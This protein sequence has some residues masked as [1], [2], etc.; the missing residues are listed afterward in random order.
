[1]TY[2]FRIAIQSRIAA[3]HPDWIPA[4]VLFKEILDQGYEGKIRILS[5]YVAKLK[6]RVPVDQGHLI[7]TVAL[8]DH[9]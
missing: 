1:M 5:D 7:K 9:P 6:P 2:Y 3:A 4:S 8:I